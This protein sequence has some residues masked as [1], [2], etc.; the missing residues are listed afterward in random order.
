M[1]KPKYGY[2]YVTWPDYPSGHPS[3]SGRPTH[4]LVEKP[5]A[6]RVDK[7]TPMARGR[8]QYIT[9]TP[10][11]DL[12]LYEGTVVVHAYSS[13][14]AGGW[15][16][17]KPKVNQCDSGFDVVVGPRGVRYRLPIV[18]ISVQKAGPRAKLEACRRLAQA[19]RDAAD[20]IEAGPKP[21]MKRPAKKAKKRS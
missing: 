3:P 11:S 12:D 21:G 14:W 17:N 2:R 20:L 5:Q 7:Y 4:L 15:A 6:A 9:T 8:M 10:T 1:K 13:W 19:M 16:E 18:V